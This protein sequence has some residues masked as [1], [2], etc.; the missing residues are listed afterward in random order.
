MCK[1]TAMSHSNFDRTVKNWNVLQF[2][3]KSTE[4]LESFKTLLKA[5]AAIVG[6]G[7][8]THAPSQKGAV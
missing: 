2:D 5:G 3:L 1:L 8:F 4:S 6:V 7:A